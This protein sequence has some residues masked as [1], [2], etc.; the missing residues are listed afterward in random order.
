MQTFQT[1][2]TLLTVLMYI[3]W[4][5]V[6]LCG[7]AGLIAIDRVGPMAIIGAGLFSIFG[8]LVIGVAQMG[9]AQIATAENTGKMLEIMRGQSPLGPQATPASKTSTTANP[10]K[11]IG[12]R[13]IGELLTTYKG[14]EIKR[15]QDGVEVDGEKF[16][17]LLVAE[18]WINQKTK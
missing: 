9:L 6:A 12:E 4:A 5:F 18:K 10:V 1:A 8:F 14:Y 13:R 7:V 3:G 17:N 15:A 11:A 16:Q 2:K